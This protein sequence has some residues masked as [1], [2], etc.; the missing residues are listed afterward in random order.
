MDLKI[1]VIDRKRKRWDGV[2]SVEG[3][4]RI[5]D[6]FSED[7]YMFL[8]LW[9]IED[10]ERQWKEGIERLKEHS[11]SCL[12]TMIH[13]PL[14][15]RFINW[16]A[17]YKIDEKIYIRNYLFVGD[18]YE[19]GIGNKE[20]TINTCYD[21]IPPRYI[22]EQG[23]KYAPSEWVVDAVYYGDTGYHLK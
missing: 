18:M 8:D 21:F 14:I 11:V 15:R 3:Q 20:F 6:D 1:S 10:Y 17:L 22:A 9:S 23:D 12:I 19:D 16:W 4:I 7:F 2:W 13:D 5:G